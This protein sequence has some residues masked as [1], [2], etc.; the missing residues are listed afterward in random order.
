[1]TTKTLTSSDFHNKWHPE[2]PLCVYERIRYGVGKKY[3]FEDENIKR[4]EQEQ[5]DSDEESIESSESEE[6]PDE[7]EETPDESNTQT[8]GQMMGDDY[9]LMKCSSVFLPN[10]ANIYV[11][12][13]RKFDEQGL[14]DVVDFCLRNKIYPQNEALS[15]FFKEKTGKDTIKFDDTCESDYVIRPDIHT[16]MKYNEIIPDNT[17]G[18]IIIELWNNEKKYKILSI[19]DICKFNGIDKTELE[20]FLISQLHEYY[21]NKSVFKYQ[22][23]CGC[24]FNSYCPDSNTMQSGHNGGCTIC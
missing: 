4:K 18:S 24:C 3:M 6:T 19:D 22:V 16:N 14:K 8:I 2:P 7:S 15:N 11:S 5:Q 12:F 21:K 13:G 10:N 17:T 23:F 20:E 9:G 1:M